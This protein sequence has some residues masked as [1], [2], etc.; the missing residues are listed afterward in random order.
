M[1]KRNAIRC[2]SCGDI[3]ESKH[4]HDFKSCSCKNV[5]VDGGLQYLKRNAPSGNVNEWYEELSEFRK[6]SEN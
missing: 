3:I 6:I 4:V 5:S 1:I 2:L